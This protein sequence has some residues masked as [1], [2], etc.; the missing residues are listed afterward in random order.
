MSSARDFRIRL[1]Q[2]IAAFIALSATSAGMATGGSGCFYGTGC[3]AGEYDT[4]DC[5][6]WP[7]MAGGTAGFG[8]MGGSGGGAVAGMGGMGGSGG[9]DP[10]ACPAQEEA[11]SHFQY[12]I[13]LRVN[14]P[15]T[16]NAETGQCCYPVTYQQICGEG[17][18]FL[19]DQ[20]PRTAELA[21]S[22]QKNG[23]VDST[24]QPDLSALSADERA[25]LSA[26]WSRAA[27]MEHASVASFA[28]FALELMAF[29]APSDLI[30]GAHQAALDEVKHAKLCFALASA[31]TGEMVEPG[32]FPMGG[33]MNLASDLADMARSTFLEGCVGETISACIAAEQLAQADDS[34]VRA[35]LSA[36]VE[37]EARHAELAFRTVAWAIRVGG[38][39][40]RAAISEAMT[41]LEIESDEHAQAIENPRLSRHGKLG[42]AYLRAARTQAFREVVG[43]AA[44][45]LV[46]QAQRDGNA[47][48]AQGHSFESCPAP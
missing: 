45:M 3:D 9:S 28:R 14:G 48:I 20:Q 10:V 5:F 21:R 32:H 30:E 33:A 4:N 15:G 26:M 24:I 29:G 37:E 19:V 35:V 2:R 17:R 12:Q 22:G 1:A 25:L 41:G 39:R 18:P 11:K 31:Y 16:F 44:L 34:A 46:R 38:D 40:V 13:P 7:A 8:G 43:P 23:W 42:G 36:V 6:Q 47:G 27:L